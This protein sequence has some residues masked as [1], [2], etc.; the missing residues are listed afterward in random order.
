MVYTSEQKASRL[1]AK[2][3]WNDRNHYVTTVVCRMCGDTI[4]GVHAN[5]QFCS[6]QCL[7]RRN[8]LRRHNLTPE[9]YNAMVAE[10]QGM[11]LI[12]GADG[13]GVVLEVDHDH[14]CCPGKHSCGKCIRGLPC[15]TCNL[16]LGIA[17][18][19]IERLS[20]LVQYLGAA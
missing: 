9:Q 18:D 6:A 13:D 15:H 7:H 17:Q 11:C 3:R 19:S 10:Q 1:A 20:G 8:N 4:A 2:R 5:R 12:C 14:T 16:T